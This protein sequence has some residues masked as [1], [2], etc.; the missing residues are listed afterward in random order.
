MPTLKK[1]ERLQYLVGSVLW[2]L[3][4]QFFICEQITRLAWKLPYSMAFSL[5]SDLGAVHCSY[6]PDAG[7]S[8]LPG[9]CSPL[10][11]VMNGSLMVQGCLILG[12]AV[13]LRRMFPDGWT[14]TAAMFLLAVAGIAV[15]FVGIAP[16][17]TGG[18]L[19]G[20]CAG[21]FFYG[22]NLGMLLIGIG[23]RIS[24]R[25]RRSVPALVLG[26][27]GLLAILLMPAGNHLLVGIGTIER[28]A[29]YPLPFFLM[30]TGYTFLRRLRRG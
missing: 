10:H 26:G 8:V 3:T 30:F 16:E 29:A 13:L 7:L 6:G 19:H 15:S 22:S 4:F 21:L 20:E 17:D 24:G 27:V 12:G 5:I 9:V 11:N 1:S 23:Y 25:P 28:L 2:V 18:E 14:F